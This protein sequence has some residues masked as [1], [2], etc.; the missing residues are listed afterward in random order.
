MRGSPYYAKGRKKE[1]VLLYGEPALF[2]W[3][4]IP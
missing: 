2:L 3:C 4:V 1:R